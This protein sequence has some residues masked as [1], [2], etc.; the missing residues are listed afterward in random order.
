MSPEIDQ[1]PREPPHGR[2]RRTPCPEPGALAALAD[3]CVADAAALDA[4]LAACP[5]CRAELESMRADNDLLATIGA[6]AE[7]VAPVPAA[8]ID[9]YTVLDEVHRGAQ[10]IVCRAVQHATRRTVALKIL[11]AGALAT[12]SQRLRFD[13]EIDALARLRHPGIVTVFDSGTS[14]DGRHWFAMEF[15]DGTPLDA[16]VEAHAARLG[17]QGTLR[18]MASVCGAVGAAHRSGVIHRDLKPDNVLVDRDGAARVVDFGLARPIDPELGDADARV[19]MPGGLLGTLAY[20][21]PEQAS[22]EPDR[23]DTR[24][25]V[26]S[27]GVMLFELL[28]GAT[29]F[30]MHGRLSE[31]LERIA[32][33]P[34]PPPSSAPTARFRIDADL[35]TIV[36]KALSTS[37]D[38][39]YESADA[40]RADLERYL[41][42]EPIE[43]RRDSRSYLLRMLL[44]RHRAAVTTASLALLALIAFTV[45]MT[46][47]H[48]RAVEQATAV[49]RINVF[50]EDTL[51]SVSPTDRP[52]GSARPRDETTVRELLDEGTH[53]VELA[54]GDEPGIEASV[55]SILGAGYRN[56]GAFDD[57]NAQLVESLAIRTARF[58][59]QSLE[60]ATSH[61]SLGLLR[62]AEGRLDEARDHLQHALRIRADRLGGHGAPVENAKSN[63]ALLE[64]D[65]R[66]FAL[67]ESLLSE[68]LTQRLA[69]LGDGHPDVAMTRYTLAEVL[70]RAGDEGGAIA[71]HR[72]AL[73]DR[74]GALAP[75]HPDVARSAHATATLAE[76]LGRDAECEPL[77]RRAER[78][79]ARSSDQRGSGEALVAV[80]ASLARADER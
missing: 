74:L 36:L 12:R 76:A 23:A 75:E 51:G 27:L 19:T 77:L 47:M 25:D 52:D 1:H 60:V 26:Y 16:H 45:A 39:R 70:R 30:P 32:S 22:G 9:G 35:D 17:L 80:R 6:A 38:R 41:G 69:R 3:G 49:A 18:L 37:P 54:V 40:F 28:T 66:R 43:A 72:Q 71:L 33:T 20:A 31:V 65:C 57:A 59:P 11:R 8:P 78:A 44:R 42:G 7:A 58:G 63:L 4:H 50:L 67:A 79:L 21:S 13:R 5:R 10:G 56:I 68:V 29:P 48:R 2:E 53:W 62:H 24:S 61:S 73:A 34:A 46:A 64:A 55:R 14:A 15:V